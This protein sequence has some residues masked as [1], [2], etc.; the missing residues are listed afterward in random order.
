MVIGRRTR[1]VNKRFNL[2][3]PAKHPLRA[4]GSPSPRGFYPAANR[5]CLT[6]RGCGHDLF[7]L[8]LVSMVQV[9]DP[10]PPFSV[11]SARRERYKV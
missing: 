11:D 10:D 4:L 1:A 8:S 2:L 5:F 9:C 6:A 7:H 3:R